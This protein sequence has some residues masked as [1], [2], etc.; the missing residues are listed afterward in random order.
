MSEGGNRERA[1]SLFEGTGFFFIADRQM[2]Q[3][4]VRRSAPG[5]KLFDGTALKLWTWH[6]RW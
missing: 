5:C 6:K 2:D 1:G 3:P 4:H